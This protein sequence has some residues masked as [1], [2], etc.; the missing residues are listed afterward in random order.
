MGFLAFLLM[1]IAAWLIW[2]GRLRR[3]TGMDGAM[4]GVAIVSAIMA[5]KGRIWL[6]GGGLLVAGIYAARAM[7]KA[8]PKR[9]RPEPPAVAEA[10]ALLGVS[11]DSNETAIR[12]AHRRLI[13]KVHP[14]AGG[15]SALA[16]KINEARNIL[17]RHQLDVNRSH[18]PNHP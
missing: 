9:A 14:D 8:S 10:R 2:T 12:E 1:A 15:T 16:E 4:L 6:G 11:A 3:M 13:A 17:L 18:S 5:A 7:R